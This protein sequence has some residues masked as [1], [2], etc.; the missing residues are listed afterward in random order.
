LRILVGFKKIFAPKMSDQV[1]LD[2]AAHE[3]GRLNESS[4][5]NKGIDTDAS[6]RA[7]RDEVNRGCMVLEII[8]R[9]VPVLFSIEDG[10]IVRRNN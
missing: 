7:V 9:D 3:N 1:L 5:D 2:Q 8:Q 6:E 10:K 4:I